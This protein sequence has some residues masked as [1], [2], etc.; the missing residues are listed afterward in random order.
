MSHF[1]DVK[2]VYN[3]CIIIAR[4]KLR[5]DSVVIAGT[6]RRVLRIHF[7]IARVLEEKAK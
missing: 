6:D 2:L 5:E 1:I 7:K 4:N 3:T